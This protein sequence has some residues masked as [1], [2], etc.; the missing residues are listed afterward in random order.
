MSELQR[1]LFIV[2]IIVFD[3]PLKMWNNF[4]SALLSLSSSSLMMV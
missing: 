3:I 4:I 1:A 2:A